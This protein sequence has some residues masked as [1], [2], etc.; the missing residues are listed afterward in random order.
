VFPE[1]VQDI[2]LVEI[3]AD[4]N[5]LFEEARELHE[6]HKGIRQSLIGY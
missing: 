3:Q 2:D 4:P 5:E 6:A 1:D